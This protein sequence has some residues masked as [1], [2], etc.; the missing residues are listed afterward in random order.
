MRV[1]DSSIFVEFSV[2]DPNVN[3]TSH[4]KRMKD[5]SFIIFAYLS[6]LRSLCNR[7]INCT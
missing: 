3:R 7:H 2:D 4:A 6:S 1:D 5:S